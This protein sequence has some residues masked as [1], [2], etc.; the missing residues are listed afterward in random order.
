MT[1]PTPALIQQVELSAPIPDIDL[2]RADGTAY[3]SVRIVAR[4]HGTVVGVV[5]VGAAGQRLVNRQDVARELW[6]HLRAPITEHLLDDGGSAPPDLAA[7]AGGLTSPRCRW[8]H[9]LREAHPKVSVVVTAIAA[10]PGVHQVLA[11]VAA[12]RL[13]AHEVLLVDNRPGSSQL[14]Q[15]AATCGVRYVP[16]A[17]RGLAAARNAGWRSATGDIIAFTDDDVR[18]DRDWTG[19]LAAP[20]TAADVGCVTGLILPRSLETSEQTLVE[21]F[22]GFGKGFAARTF[23]MADPPSDDP[24]FPYAAG[25]FGS[26]ACAALRRSALT[27]VDGF[28]ERL[29]TGTPAR[30]GEDLDVFVR[31]L[32]AGWAVHYTPAAVVWH[33][34]RASA[35]AL[36][37]QAY[38]YGVGLAAFLMARASAGAQE[39]RAIAARMAAGARYAARRFRGHRE[40]GAIRLPRHLAV[41]EVLGIIAGPV[42][43]YRSRRT[44][45]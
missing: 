11:D 14:E 29:G 39:R 10:S 35:P 21:D 38:S 23:S 18:L 7:V 8:E 32:R 9:L 34:H 27:N 31:V 42:H 12:Q 19:A 1:L 44:N 4:L 30:G 22:S 20:F 43:Y 25:R 41:L 26:G 37:A 28:D 16:A 33:E 2:R 6:K 15:T 24:L 36:R 45:G 40:D 5:D 17:K 3:R 13:P